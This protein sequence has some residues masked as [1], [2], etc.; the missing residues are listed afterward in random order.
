MNNLA[1]KTAE[2]FLPLEAEEQL[3]VMIRQ[4][5]PGRTAVLSSFGAESA[6]LLD[7]VAR[8]DPATPVIFLDTGMHFRETLAYKE[9]LQKRLGLKDIRSVGPKVATLNEL[10]PDDTLHKRDHDACCSLR[11]VT[12]LQSALR[13]F[14]AL[15]TGRKRYHG[16]G[17][18]Q[19]PS[20][21]FSD[22][23]IKHNPLAGWSEE[24]ID[25]A[26]DQRGLPRHP[27]TFDDYLSLGCAPCTQ[28]TKCGGN[29]RTGRW[30][31]SGKTE[32][33]IHTP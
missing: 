3:S 26:F 16:D 1:V 30:A 13:G 4:V 24:Q 9:L 27:L 10:D 33:G 15:I 6:V 29:I 8:I 21:E 23:R 7:M 19:L 31:G 28:K 25:R 32:C 14:D 20:I 12:P 18:A 5:F 11:K 17:R 22:G 2:R